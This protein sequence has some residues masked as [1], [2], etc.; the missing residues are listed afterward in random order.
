[1]SPSKLT[2][3]TTQF[4]PI[5]LV[6]FS[7]M[8]TAHCTNPAPAACILQS[9]VGDRI[10]LNVAKY[11]IFRRVAV[12]HAVPP[13]VI[14]SNDDASHLQVHQLVANV[15]TKWSGRIQALRIQIGVLWQQSGAEF[16]TRKRKARPARLR[17]VR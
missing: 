13:G 14:P 9:Y 15:P 6:H 10:E 17:R 2:A 5:T 8:P 16:E 4:P 1:M 3:P 11:L 12:A 7:E